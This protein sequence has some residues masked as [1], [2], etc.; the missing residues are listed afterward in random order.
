MQKL[1]AR[2]IKA[3]KEFD[4]I[5]DGDTVAVGVSGGKDSMLL[6]YLLHEISKF[7]EKKFKVIC[8]SLDCTN[9]SADFSETQKFFVEH[10]IDFEIIK[11]DIFEV[12]F[13]IRKE[14]N[15]CSLC[16]NLR[17]G[18]LNARAKERGAAKIALGHHADDFI[19][20]Y[21]LSMLY[22]GRLHTFSPKTYFSRVD[23]TQIRPMLYIKEHEVESAIKRLKIPVINNCCKANK[24]TKRQLVKDELA[25]L[26]TLVP[27]C[28]DQIFNA[29]LKYVKNSSGQ[30]N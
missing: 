5:N 13:E 17:R 3:I 12:V 18:Q 22:E 23:L 28:K 1:I 19:E 7:Y 14:K 8:I 11:T 25:R 27:A 9:G 20:T 4:L 10:G 24:N 2:L 29:V 21:F 16:A 30:E 26:E 6:A 15:P